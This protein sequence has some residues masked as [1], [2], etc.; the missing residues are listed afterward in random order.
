MDMD[1]IEM[2]AIGHGTLA[3]QTQASFR[4]SN[5]QCKIK[6]ASLALAER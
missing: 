6:T 5:T 4:N 3:Q 1:T 2:H